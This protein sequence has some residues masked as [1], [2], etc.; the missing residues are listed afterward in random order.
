MNGAMIIG[1]PVMT[2]NDGAPLAAKGVLEVIELNVLGTRL[3]AA[4]P[5]QPVP[6]ICFMHLPM[7]LSW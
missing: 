6:G 3:D 5:T 4:H 2:V 1:L 7:D